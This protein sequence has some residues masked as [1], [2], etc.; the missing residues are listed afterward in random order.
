[1]T[2][3]ALI[4]FPLVLAAGPAAAVSGMGNCQHPAATA[5]AVMRHGHCGA[6]GC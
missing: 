5:S 1:V 2:V 3:A 4:A 6:A